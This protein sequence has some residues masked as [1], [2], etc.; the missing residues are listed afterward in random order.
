[1]KRKL[2]KLLLATIL[3]GVACAAWPGAVREIDSAMVFFSTS[4]LFSDYL[5]LKCALAPGK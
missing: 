4:R 1:M 2:K 5:V 3:I